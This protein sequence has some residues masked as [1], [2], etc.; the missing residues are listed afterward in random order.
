LVGVVALVLGACGGGSEP[1]SEDAAVDLA[2]E[3]V[4]AG[5]APYE[6]SVDRDS[7]SG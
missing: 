4:G 6:A 7:D 1:L 5:E 3:H 2:R